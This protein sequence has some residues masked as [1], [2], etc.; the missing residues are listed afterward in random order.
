MDNLDPVFQGILCSHFPHLAKKPK[1]ITAAGL[2][3]WLA[4]NGFT[5][6]RIYFDGKTNRILV[7]VKLPDGGGHRTFTLRAILTQ[8]DKV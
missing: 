1:G 3:D 7:E 8:V 5:D 6:E 4:K 2:R